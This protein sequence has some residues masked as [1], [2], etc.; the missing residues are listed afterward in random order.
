M[1]QNGKHHIMAVDDQPANLKLLEDLLTRQGHLVRSFPRGRL[2]LEAAARNPPDLI[3]LDINMPEMSGFKVCELLKSDE[4]LAAIPVIFLSALDDASDKVHAF[5]C[6]GVDYVSKPFQVDEVQARVEAHLKI[7]QLQRELQMHASHLEE[8]VDARTV[9]LAETQERLKVLD[10]AKGDFLRLIH[11]ELRSPLNG[12]LGVG[13]LVLDE[14]GESE[15]AAELREMFEQ[16]RKRMLTI[17]DDALLLTEIEVSSDSFSSEVADLVPTLEGAIEA[18]APFA[19]SRGVRIELE[20]GE[21]GHGVSCVV[22]RRD[23][24]L[25]AIQALLEAAVKFC[26]SGDSVR[27]HCQRA[28]EGVL[29]VI[30]GPGRMP[31]SAIARFFQVFSISE[32][33]TPGGDLGLGPPVAQRIL[34]LFGGSIAVENLEPVGIQLTVTLKSA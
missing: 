11:H 12:L 14:I 23:L 17:L 21:A 28:G 10:R 4:K 26:P 30:R 3:L 20:P 27:V 25:K 13:E 7:H 16:S 5:Q 32:A 33:I 19:Q 31:E 6:G 29:V 1:A 24:L 8:L 34:A 22:A 9:E 15:E 2:A 18:A